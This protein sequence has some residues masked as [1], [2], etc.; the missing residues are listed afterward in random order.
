M[1]AGSEAQ[2]VEDI[3]DDKKLLIC[4]YLSKEYSISAATFF[5]PS[6]V[7]SPDQTGLEDGSKRVI[8]SFRATGEGHISTIV[9]HTGVIDRNNEIHI[10]KA[11]NHVDQP[12]AVKRH[13]YEKKMTID[14]L[15]E[16]DVRQDSV[17]AVLGPLNDTFIYGEFLG[18]ALNVLKDPSLNEEERRAVELIFFLQESPYEISYSRDTHLSERVFF[19]ISYTERR[20]IEDARFVR[21]VDDEGN[22]TYY[23]TYSA[24]DG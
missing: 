2:A 7:E 20:G 17:D 6:M 15:E 1:T 16:M 14:K 11:G 23:A 24:Y 5:N 21:F 10:E 18:S 4:S 3:S 22:A 8:I 12:E 13:V 19:P 9:F